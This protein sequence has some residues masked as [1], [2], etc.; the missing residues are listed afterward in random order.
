MGKKKLEIQ[1]IL[2]LYDIFERKKWIEIEGHEET[3]ARFED[4]LEVLK[5]EQVDLFL[6]LTERF[7]WVSLNEYSIQLR[8]LLQELHSKFLL[9]INS[10]YLFPILGSSNDAKE[11]KSGQTVMY[12]LDSIKRSLPQYRDIEFVKLNSFEEL[13]TQT[14]LITDNQLLVLVDDFIGSGKTLNATIEQVNKIPS[15]GDKFVVLSIVIQEETKTRLDDI[16]TKNVVG[17]IGKKGISDYYVGE[18]LIEKNKVMDSI[19][20]LIPKVKDY[21]FGFKRSEALVSMMKTPNNTFP[22]FWKDFMKKG[23]LYKA[24]FPRY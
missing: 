23:E 9:D 18:E 16:N 13:A 2:K 3:R 20:S 19:E 11:T 24:P 5:N 22:I 10:V 8:K 14:S 7:Y 4:L 12:M 15:I 1:S 17:R 21:R 6:D